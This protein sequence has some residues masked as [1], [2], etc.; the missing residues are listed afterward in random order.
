MP[1]LRANDI[2]I[3]WRPMPSLEFQFI[4][5]SSRISLARCLMSVKP[6]DKLGDLNAI[7]PDG[8]TTVPSEPIPLRS[9]FPRPE[10]NEAKRPEPCARTRFRPGTG[11]RSIVRGNGRGHRLDPAPVRIQARDLNFGDPRVGNA[12]PPGRGL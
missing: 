4:F 10:E 6:G 8:P 1:T 12:D 2:V 7:T 11:A 3:G 9:L 5:V